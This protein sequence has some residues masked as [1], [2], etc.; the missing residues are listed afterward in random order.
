M[1][2][3]CKLVLLDDHWRCMQEQAGLMRSPQHRCPFLLLI[4]A[5]QRT[6]L[7]QH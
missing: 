7:Q 2:L 3:T 4:P 1:Q 5:L 6:I